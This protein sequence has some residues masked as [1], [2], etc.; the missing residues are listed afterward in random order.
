MSF[1]QK[2]VSLLRRFGLSGIPALAIALVLV[3]SQLMQSALAL[4]AGL[5]TH[6]SLGIGAGPGDTW[7]P[8]SG[9]AW[10]YRFQYLSGGVN[11]N[12]GWETWNAN[13]TFASN[14]AQESA[15]HGYIPMFPYYEILQ[16][17]GNCNTCPENQRDITNLNTPAVMQAYYNNFTVLMKRLGPGSHDGIA[18]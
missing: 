16:S 3:L 11:N 10:D 13:G 6:F 15:Q 1:V 4:P 2:R 7:M 9:I 14:Y 8:Q 12:R 18:G 5:P 17:S